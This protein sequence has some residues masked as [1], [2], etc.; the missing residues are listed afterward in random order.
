MLLHAHLG[1]RSGAVGTTAAAMFSR[2]GRGSPSG[3]RDRVRLNRPSLDP[4]CQI[5]SAQQMR[6]T[7]V[8]E[9]AS[10]VWAGLRIFSSH[11]WH[12]SSRASITSSRSR[13]CG[14]ATAA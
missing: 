3:A 5:S 7:E 14:T 8:L 1:L 9:G 11:P 4:A 10:I 13:I 6:I 12:R 2:L